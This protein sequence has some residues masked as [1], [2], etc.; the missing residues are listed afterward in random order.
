MALQFSVPVLRRTGVGKEAVGRLRRSGRVPAVLYGGNKEAVPL[1]V[2]P[3]ALAA[4]LRSDTGHNTVFEVV[5]DGEG[6]EKTA[7]MI[8]DWQRDPVRGSLLHVDLKRIALDRRIRVKAPIRSHGEA[9]GVKAQ[10][11]VLELVTRE[12]E[13]ECLPDQI[14][15]F[16]A[17]DVSALAIGQN[18]RVGD[19]QL[20]AGLKLLSAPDRVVA[21]VVAVKEEVAPTPVE[22]AAEVATPA[23]PEVAKKGKA[24][25]PAAEEAAPAPAAKEGKKKA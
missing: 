9:M 16:I 13:L 22:A 5:M 14:P 24:E 21:H 2:D 25:A 20:A 1:S 6:G 8:V 23:E 18:L 3:K 19:L 12:I 4:I 10:G 7:A 17:V 11:G 15:D